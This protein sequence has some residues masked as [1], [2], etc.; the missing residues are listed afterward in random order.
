[1]IKLMQFMFS[2][3]TTLYGFNEWVRL[4]KTRFSNIEEAKREYPAY[5]ESVPEV[6]G[7]A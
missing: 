1:M 3:D 4:V 7:A 6:F 2:G 5:A